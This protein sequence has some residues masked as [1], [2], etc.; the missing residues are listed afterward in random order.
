[1][2]LPRFY[3]SQMPPLIASLTLSLLSYFPE[4]NSFVYMSECK[5]NLKSEVLGLEFRNDKQTHLECKICMSFA[6][7][8]MQL[9][10]LCKHA[11][12]IYLS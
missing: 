6:C 3:S 7:A 2:M 4:S 1:M 11:F 12:H 10:V 8:Q 9:H 5:L